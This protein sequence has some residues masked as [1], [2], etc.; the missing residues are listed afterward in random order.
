MYWLLTGRHITT[1]IPKGIGGAEQS[2]PEPTSPPNQL[3]PDVPAAL[4]AL[5][6]QCIET[7]PTDRPDSMARVR[8]RLDLAIGQLERRASPPPAEAV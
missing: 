8:D 3:R 6:M 5:V 4:S 1:M 7:K 2:E